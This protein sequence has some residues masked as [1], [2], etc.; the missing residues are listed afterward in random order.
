MFGEK[1]LAFLNKPQGI[2]RFPVGPPH[3]Y[4]SRIYGWRTSYKEKE[5]NHGIF[6]KKTSETTG[7]AHFLLVY[8]IQIGVL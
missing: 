4:I 6:E 8:C 7:M 1:R 5:Q 3:L 2:D